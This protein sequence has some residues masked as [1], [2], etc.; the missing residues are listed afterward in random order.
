MCLSVKKLPL[1]RAQHPSAAAGDNSGAMLLLPRLVFLLLLLTSGVALRRS[2][3]LQHG[4]VGRMH[5]GMRHGAKF[6]HAARSCALHMAGIKELRPTLVSRCASDATASKRSQHTHTHTHS[7]LCVPAPLHPS[8]STC[9]FCEPGEA[10][11]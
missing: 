7:D 2:V 11:V 4:K 9:T 3:G 8:L 5:R 10:A 6:T 1:L